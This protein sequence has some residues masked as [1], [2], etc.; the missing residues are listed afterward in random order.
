MDGNDGSGAGIPARLVGYDRPMTHDAPPHGDDAQPPRPVRAAAVALVLGAI[1][2][3]IGACTPPYRWWMGPPVEEFLGLVHA[4]LGTWRFIAAAF[5]IAAVVTLPALALLTARLR[6][7]GDP[8][9]SVVGLVLFAAGTPLWLLHLG[10]RA[11]VVPWAAAEHARTGLVPTGFVAERQWM[12]LAFAAYMVLAYLGV[13]A[14]GAALA[15]TGVAARVGR[16][17]VVFGL[18]A[19]P[20]LATPV[21][22]P[23]LMVHV[24]PFAIGI[25]LLR[26]R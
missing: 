8:G 14:Y 24:M 11:A 9:W 21:F 22:Q 20:G 17:A 10:H 13:A 16:A 7:V 26:A 1:V 6:T 18:V 4:H 5:A 25:A 23:P 19:V 2:F 15:R 3:W 12:G